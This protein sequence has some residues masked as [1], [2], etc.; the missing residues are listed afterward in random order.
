MGAPIVFDIIAR[1]KASKTFSK[2]GGAAKLLGVVGLGA[3]VKNAV[4]TEAA[5]GKTMNLMQAGS[6][7]SGKEMDKLRALAIKMGADTQFSAGQAADAM[8]ELSK[9]GISPAAIQAGA[10]QGTLTLAAAGGL[11]MADAAGI[12]GNALNTFGLEAKDMN[13]VA[14]ALAGGA[15]AST[16]S[17][18]SMGQALRQVGPGAKTA[19]LSIQETTAVL[20]A[21]DNAG[22]KGS[23]A[24]TSLKTMLTR[25]VPTTVK[26]KN[27]MAD[28]GLK[29]TD[30]H[31]KFKSISN[32]SEQLR[33]KMGKLSDAERTKAMNTIFGSD[34]TRAATV[35]MGQGAKGID[36]LIKKTSDQRAAQKMANASMKG[37][38]GALERMSGSLE[39]ASLAIGQMLAPLVVFLADHVG[40]AANAFVAFMPTINAAARALAS[41][42][43]PAI[44]GIIA[45]GSK[46]GAS[47][48]PAVLSLGRTLLDVLVP[49]FVATA[50]GVAAVAGFFADHQTAAL[51]LA[52]TIGALVA[53]TK[54]HA[55]V[56]AV[57]AAGGLLA[58]IKATKTATAVM[59]AA[60]AVQWIWTA[61]TGVGNTTLATRIGVLYLDAVAWVK[62]TAA[63]AANKVATLAGAA[64]TAVATGAQAAYTAVTNALTLSNIRSVAVMTATRVA[65]MA[66]AAATA[67]MT[68]AQWAL[69]VAMTANPIVLVVVGLVALGAALVVAYKK[70]ETFRKIVNAAFHGALA[71]VK[72]VWNWIKKNWPL[73]L[74]ILTGP[75]GLA[76]LVI[77]KNWDKIKSGATAVKDFVA[78]KFQAIG[79]KIGQLPAKIRDLGSKML[80]A[81]KGLMNDLFDG[82]ASAARGVGGFVADLVSAI[83]NAINS[84][85][86]LPFT[87]NGPGPLPDF[88]IPA[89]ARG[90]TN[91]S[92]G[93][94]YVHQGEVLANLP[95]GTDVIP[96]NRV[97]GGSAG[98][99]VTIIINGPTDPQATAREI[100]K[101]LLQLKRTS[102]VEL[103]LA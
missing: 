41:D 83:R 93:L 30:S 75:I 20:A 22:I 99:G 57:Q 27:A 3:V 56:M 26:A 29:F 63:M 36:K 32:I 9:S 89:F 95:A 96:A 49:A 7:A 19:G 78:D 8:L 103:G 98:G 68:A 24:G 17:V 37:T 21:F 77:A 53:I 15:N 18:E 43:T 16:A 54:I 58:M 25:L 46:L 28:L 85:L 35:L 62:S 92:G 71:A 87:I 5:F 23:D 12:A 67:V 91:F 39:T 66:G 80:Q 79:E 42:L 6:G 45:A 86:H 64:A 10:L 4:S 73:L 70:S 48:G 14:A 102:G 59:K 72:F 2:I 82:I 94:A 65:L 34:A 50:E 101:I 100:R 61:A 55:A 13:S 31:G 81:G 44:Q 69:N 40:A 47:V 38:A 74:A 76:A 11:E 90:V 51:A 60:A 33:Q 88:T 97:G 84:A 52:A 1:D